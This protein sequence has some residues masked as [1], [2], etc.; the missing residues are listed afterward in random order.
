MIL[1]CLKKTFFSN[2]VSPLNS[3]LSGVRKKSQV[4]VSWHTN[5]ADV[6]RICFWL[7]DLVGWIDREQLGAVVT[8]CCTGWIVNTVTQKHWS[9]LTNPSSP[10]EKSPG[11]TS[12]QN[13]SPWASSTSFFPKGFAFFSHP[14]S[15]TP[16]VSSTQI[17]LLL[18][19]SCH[20]PSLHPPV[21]C[22]WN[23]SL[24]PAHPPFFTKGTAFVWGWQPITIF[25]SCR[26]NS[27]A[28]E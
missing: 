16:L 22:Y 18:F 11:V 13:K 27:L 9:H 25:Q 5:D 21:S 20:Q 19:K 23:K 28:K 12:P 15:G 4:S 3:D 14:S 6:F 8:T 1:S 26:C 24:T 10:L 17:L 7:S 2:Y